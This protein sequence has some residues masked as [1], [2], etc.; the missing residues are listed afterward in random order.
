[1]FEFARYFGYS[2]WGAL[3]AAWA[4]GWRTATCAVAFALLTA[5]SAMTDRVPAPVTDASILPA[6]PD[7]EPAPVVLPVPPALEP[8]PVRLPAPRP[9]R[10]P[11]PKPVRKP[12]PPRK[13]PPAPPAPTVA[14]KAPLVVA[15]QDVP[16][17]K[18]RGMLDS[19]V[20]RAGGSVIGRAVDAVAAMNGSPQAIV[21]NLMGFMGVGDRKV[22]LP[23]QSVRFNPAAHGQPPFTLTSDNVEP[24]ASSPGSGGS[25]AAPAGMMNLIDATV[26]TVKGQE[27]GHV[28]DILLDS[29]GQPQGVVLN[30]SDSLIHDKHLIAASWSAL[31]L[32][33]DAKAPRLETDLDEKQIEA[34]PEFISGK[35][36]RLVSPPPAPVAADAPKA[37]E[38]PAGKSD[39]AKGKDEPAK[40]ADEAAEAKSKPGAGKDVAAPA[41]ASAGAARP[42]A[43]AS[44]SVGNAAGVSAKTAAGARASAPSPAKQ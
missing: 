40:R 28:V 9:V 3:S 7:D 2:L 1:L 17:G 31:H 19:E 26:R 21:V 38:T 35:P 6:D 33:G 44:Q 18:M 23:W 42:S 27:V 8:N 22:R 30:I 14:P 11:V 15:I 16:S 12:P 37:D 36:I 24:S 41:G 25:P 29:A 20:Q 4:T 34:S 43:S 13:E 5:C 32:R 10:R 39:A